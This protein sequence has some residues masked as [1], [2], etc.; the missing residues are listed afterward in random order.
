MISNKLLA[1]AEGLL[2]SNCRPFTEADPFN[3]KNMVEGLIG[4]HNDHR[5]GALWITSVNGVPEEQFIYATPKLHYPFDRVGRYNFPSAQTIETYTKLDGTN[6]FMFRYTARGQTFISYKTRLRPFLASMGRFGDFLDMWKEMLLN[7]PDIPKLFLTNPQMDGFSF[8]LYGSLNKHLMKYSIALDTALLFAIKGG[9]EV[10]EVVPPSWLSLEDMAVPVA[11][12]ESKVTSNYV[13]EYEQSQE[14]MNTA[15]KDTDMGLEG[16][17]GTVWYLLT[18]DGV[19]MQFKCKPEQIENIHWAAG[20]IPK[21][22]L[23]A[24]AY[25]VLES[26]PEI[27]KKAL[28]NL[29][30]E[31]FTQEQVDASVTRIEAI[32]EEVKTELEFQDRVAVILEKLLVPGLL[33]D[34][35]LT[36]PDVMRFLSNHFERGEMSIVYHH[37]TILLE[38]EFGPQF[39]TRDR[40]CGGE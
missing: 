3:P 10:S 36:L 25:N 2:G 12:L 21:L 27:T 32:L 24:T 23:K 40:M 33:V 7:Y 28:V 16:Q 35:E 5:Y 15:L 9:G 6:I 11:A 38:K 26:E 20:G 31:E 8:E 14:T 19:W 29:L 30:L 17:E 18:K 37:A 39:L 4:T 34:Y 13:W 1:I 22:M